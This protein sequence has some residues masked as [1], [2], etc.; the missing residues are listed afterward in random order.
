MLKGMRVLLYHAK[1]KKK[2]VGKV[3]SV[4]FTITI[5]PWLLLC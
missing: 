5:K 4:L 2:L 1:K 3:A